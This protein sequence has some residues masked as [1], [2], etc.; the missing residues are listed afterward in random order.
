MTLVPLTVRPVAD[1]LTAPLP[2]LTDVMHAVTA[3]FG[4]GG[5]TLRFGPSD[6]RSVVAR[7]ADADGAARR[8]VGTVLGLPPAAV[9]VRITPDRDTLS[10]LRRTRPS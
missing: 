5:W 1:P 10:S 3:T 7:L 2:R 9:R 8:L 6:H 4:A